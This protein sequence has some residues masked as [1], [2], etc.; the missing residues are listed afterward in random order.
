MRLDLHQAILYVA[1]TRKGYRN[2]LKSIFNESIVNELA[3][4]GYISQGST[5]D[6]NDP[7]KE[8]FIR[9]WKA[10]VKSIRY[11]H[12]NTKSEPTEGKKA[13]GRFLYSIGVR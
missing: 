7:E 2:D 1:E 6:D 13:F 8:N 3:R 10:T 12:S 5:L 4:L 9:T 11:A